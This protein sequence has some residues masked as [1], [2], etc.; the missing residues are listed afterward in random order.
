MLKLRYWEA[1]P[2]SAMHGRSKMN[3]HLKWT[4]LIEF[5]F[6]GEN[7]KNSFWFHT[8]SRN[9]QCVVRR[10][11]EFEFFEKS[12]NLVTRFWGLWRHVSE[13]DS[14]AVCVIVVGTIN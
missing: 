9:L 10:E 2:N 13:A 1:F 7:K 4:C 11:G 5:L 14:A 8:H 6:L 3:L 12:R